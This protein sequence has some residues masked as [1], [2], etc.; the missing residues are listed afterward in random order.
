MMSTK[1]N[2]FDYADILMLALAG[3]LSI[4]AFQMTGAGIIAAVGV[5]FGS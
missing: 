1:N 5:I 2:K 4:P 3:F